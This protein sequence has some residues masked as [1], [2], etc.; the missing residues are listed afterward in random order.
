MQLPTDSK[1]VL[2]KRKVSN[3]IAIQDSKSSTRNQRLV[4]E[5]DQPKFI[6]GELS[7]SEKLN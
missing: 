6:T 7:N 1:R 5:T 4:T 3:P 2:K